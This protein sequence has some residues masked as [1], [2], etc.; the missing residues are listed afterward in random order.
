M[1]KTHAI[2]HDRTTAIKLALGAF[3]DSRQTAEALQLWQ[4]K[5]AG[6]P[7]FSIQYFA[8]ECCTLF[9]V[10][11]KRSQIVKSLV[12]ELYTQKLSAD[13]PLLQSTI[14][15]PQAAAATEIFQ[16]LFLALIHSTDPLSARD[17]IAYVEA[18][19]PKMSIDKETQRSLQ[20][21][22]NQ[23]KSVITMHLPLPVMIALINR[24]YVGLCEYCGPVKADLILHDAVSKVA[25]NKAAHLFHPEELL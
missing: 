13:E 15:G 14:T 20:R 23:G 24:V 1:S 19:L 16:L 11:S 2:T 8:R 12:R 6:Q 21:W 22:I 5:Y 4:D 9:G 18:G 7:T 25:K 17:I 10:E 3:L